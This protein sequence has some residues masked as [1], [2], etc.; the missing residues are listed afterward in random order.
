M[1][2]TVFISAV[3]VLVGCG[4]R[5]SDLSTDTNASTSNGGSVSRS[6][7]V[8]VSSD[9]PNEWS[10]AGASFTTK[11]AVVIEPGCTSTTVGPCT[12]NPCSVPPTTPTGVAPVPNVGAIAISV[13][14]GALAMLEV[15]ADGTYPSL[16]TS[17][18]PAWESGGETLSV[19][20]ANAPGDPGL[21][22]GSVTFATPPYVALEEGTAFAANPGTISRG[23]DLTLG[24]TTDTVAGSADQLVVDVTTN[25]AQLL[26]EFA[27]SAGAGTIPAAALALVSPGAAKYDVHAK[28]F[29]SESLLDGSGERWSAG[30]NIDAHART[31]SGLAYG[32]I[33][34]E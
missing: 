20:W 3:F 33:T 16:V 34:I 25:P 11:A 31:A 9:R 26:C 19:Q 23:G 18:T 4:A 30:F 17:A 24:W 21:P 2:R 8:T 5:A 29:G 7:N 6:V 14:G 15:Q 1:K 13:A 22:G 12:Y 10:S 28:E 27:A 32:A